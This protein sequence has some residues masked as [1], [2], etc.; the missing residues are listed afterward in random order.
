MCQ[1]V[2]ECAG[3]NSC[4]SFFGACNNTVGSYSCVCN[5]GYQGDGQAI[6]VNKD[7]CTSQSHDCSPLAQCFDN[8]GSFMCLCKAGWVLASG[9]KGTIMDL[10]A[11]LDV[12]ECLSGAHTCG[13]ANGTTCMSEFAYVCEYV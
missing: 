11:C 9:S 8:V 10:P 12:D 1:D 5:T 7:E 6:C 2:D 13:L 4:A 3:N